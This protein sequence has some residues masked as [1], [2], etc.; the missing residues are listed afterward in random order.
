MLEVNVA[1]ADACQSSPI[2]L[3]A[4][5]ANGLKTNEQQMKK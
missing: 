4:F 1:V 2:S 5:L 3:K